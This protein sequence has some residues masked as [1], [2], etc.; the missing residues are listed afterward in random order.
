MSWPMTASPCSMTLHDLVLT[1]PRRTPRGCGNTH[2]ACRD[3]DWRVT[4]IRC[5]FRNSR[6]DHGRG[7][8]R[9]EPAH[10]MRLTIDAATSLARRGLAALGY[11][12]D[13]ASLIAD[14]L[15]DCDLRGLP[16]GGLARII[17]IG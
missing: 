9:G 2:H 11:D 13:E 1:Q 10:A 7:G 17:S 8:P 6:D 14:H 4:R 5:I 15:L 16:Y 3:G 12:A